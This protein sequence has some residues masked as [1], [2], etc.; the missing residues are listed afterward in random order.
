VEGRVLTF[1]PF[2]Q[3]IEPPLNEHNHLLS[4]KVVVARATIEQV[5]A[6]EAIL[7]KQPDK[8]AAAVMLELQKAEWDL[9][10]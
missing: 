7:G 6:I 2:F 8:A 1:P 10:L 4:L 3:V 9:L 5:S